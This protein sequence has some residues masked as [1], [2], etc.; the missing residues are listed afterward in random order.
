VVENEFDDDQ[1]REFTNLTAG[2]KVSHYTIISKIGAGGMGEVYLAEDTKLHRKVAL[3]FLPSQ[4]VADADFKARFVRE[5]EATAK[6]NHPNIITIYEVSEF[7]G[8]PFF[9]ME[10]VEGQ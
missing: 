10:L 6:L 5:A 3:K 9:A 7:Q 4:Y 1:T 2:T 8:R